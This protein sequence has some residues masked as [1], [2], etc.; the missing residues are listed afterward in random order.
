[1]SR[2][3]QDTGIKL[4]PPR[5]GVLSGGA[6]RAYLSGPKATPYEGCV[7]AVDIRL[8]T[9]YPYDPPTMMFVN[10]CWHP[11][12]GVNGHVCVDI[13]QREWAPSLTILKILMSV[14]SLLDDPDPRS[15]LNGPAADMYRAAKA[16]R[17]WDRYRQMIQAKSTELYRLTEEERRFD[18]EQSVILD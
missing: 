2:E 13:L 12:I 8:P 1:M 4:R 10:R 3:K 5:D 7:Y 14:Q 17:D 18:P 6:W 16:N 11:N 9:N 15:P